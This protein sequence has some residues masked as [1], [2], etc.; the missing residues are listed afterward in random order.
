MKGW[1]KIKAPTY[2]D[3]QLYLAEYNTW[4]SVYADKERHS[5]NVVELARRWPK[6]KA[7]E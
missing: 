3:N 1:E 4:P 6:Q 5:T 2:Q 7:K